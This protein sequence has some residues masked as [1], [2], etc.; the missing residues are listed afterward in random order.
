MIGTVDRAKF[1]GWTDD[2][3]IDAVKAGDIALY[4]LLMRRYNQR[5][6][7]VTRAI[8]RNDGDVED[9]IQEAYVRAY[10][11]LDQFSGDAPFSAWLTRIAVNEALR[12]LHLRGR[13]QQFQESEQ[14]EE[15]LMTMVETSPD[16]EQRASIAE[17]GQ[18]LETAVLDLPDQ[19][20]TVVMLRDIEELSTL[21]TAAALDLTEQNVKVRLH[22]GRAMM[23]NW[24]F[25]RAGEKAK[26]A[27]PFMGERCDRVVGCVYARLNDSVID[28]H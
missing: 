17:L 25:V 2:A 1:E 23:R 10:Q 4:E 13:N 11:H 21:E 15:G 18:L 22:R 28:N 19:Y 16:P 27:F 14:D 8:L 5:L 9:V 26:T 12:R 24:L 6:Y 20:R 7:R 3:I